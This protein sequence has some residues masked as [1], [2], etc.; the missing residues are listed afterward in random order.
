MSQRIKIKKGMTA[1][2]IQDELF[3]RMSPDK[4]I[5]LMS[6]FS[7]FLKDLNKLGKENEFPQSSD[8]NRRGS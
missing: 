6:D 8:R 7:M 2:Y 3:R 4:R 5:R 1:Q